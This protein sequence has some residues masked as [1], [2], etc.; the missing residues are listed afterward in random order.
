[1]HNSWGAAICEINEFHKNFLSS[2]NLSTFSGIALLRMSA[3][4]A[5][6]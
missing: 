1:M 2:E 5:Y 4:H 6:A 3:L